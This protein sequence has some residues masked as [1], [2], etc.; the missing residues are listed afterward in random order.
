[1]TN[2]VT[3]KTQIKQNFIRNLVNILKKVVINFTV[4]QIETENI[5]YSLNET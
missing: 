2:S 3:I 5:I 4:I 1:M